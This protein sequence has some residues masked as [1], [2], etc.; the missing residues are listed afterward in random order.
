MLAYLKASI[1]SFRVNVD[2]ALLCLSHF[3]MF[4]VTERNLG[5]L[6]GEREVACTLLVRWGGTFLLRKLKSDSLNSISLQWLIACENKG[7]CR[8]L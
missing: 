6:R 1:G 7:M 5:S 3:Q 8:T 4:L 2:Y